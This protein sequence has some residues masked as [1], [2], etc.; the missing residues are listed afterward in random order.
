MIA[1]RVLTFEVATLK[2]LLHVGENSCCRVPNVFSS[3]HAGL[4]L[5][6]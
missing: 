6:Q 3:L 1:G 4:L 5:Q 2:V